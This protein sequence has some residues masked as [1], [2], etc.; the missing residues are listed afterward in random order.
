MGKHSN[1]DDRT[2]HVAHNMAALVGI[3]LSAMKYAHENL[4]D[5][6]AF[7]ARHLGH[8]MG[9]TK[10]EMHTDIDYA[11]MTTQG[12]GSEALDELSTL[13]EIDLA[14]LLGETPNL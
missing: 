1:D 6:Y 13:S 9:M 5:F 12:L 14:K 4:D 8:D 11:I 3:W 10:E 2:A 7:N